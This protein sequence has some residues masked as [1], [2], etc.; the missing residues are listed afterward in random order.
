VLTHANASFF[1]H[2]FYDINALKDTVAGIKRA[3]YTFVPAT[4]MG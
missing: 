3:G 4:D 1:F 2:P